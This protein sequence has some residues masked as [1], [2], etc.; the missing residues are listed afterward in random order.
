[1]HNTQTPKIM[2]IINN[3]EEFRHNICENV[4]SEFWED[5]LI[6]ENLER[7]IYNWTIN[8]AVERRI[9]KKWNNP[10]FVQLY[11]DHVRSI[12][13]NL[14]KNSVLCDRIISHEIDSY[15][16]AFMTHYEIDND[17][18]DPLIKEKMEI[19]KHKYEDRM[20]AT[21]DTFTC[22]NC[23]SKR[24]HDMQ[25]QTRSADEPM[26]IF[27]TCLDCGKRWRG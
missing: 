4:L 15:A 9:L 17:R 19:D 8:E 12:Q 7:G 2:R 26:T 1:M 22:R 5:N 10:Y 3:P 11:I 18:W 20:E 6:S 14:K 27:V 25:L 16:F 21:T 24:C 13:T 23:K